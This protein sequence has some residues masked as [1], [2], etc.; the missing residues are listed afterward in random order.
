MHCSRSTIRCVTRGLRALEPPYALPKPLRGTR[1]DKAGRLAQFYL[2]M[3]RVSEEFL[4]GRLQPLLG[5]LSPEQREK[6]PSIC[7]RVACAIVVGLISWHALCCTALHL[8]LTHMCA[9]HSVALR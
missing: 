3:D 2:E 4:W 1:A 7:I 8:I 9:L 5:Y 6:V